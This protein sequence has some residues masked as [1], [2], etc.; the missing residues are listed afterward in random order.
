[1]ICVCKKKLAKNGPRVSPFSKVETG[2]A[3]CSKINNGREV[4]L[5]VTYR[6]IARRFP[7]LRSELLLRSRMHSLFHAESVKLSSVPVEMGK[8]NLRQIH[9][10]CFASMSQV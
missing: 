6:T 5:Y 9:Y 8:S 7:I 1:M 4:V 3:P 10:T 2:K